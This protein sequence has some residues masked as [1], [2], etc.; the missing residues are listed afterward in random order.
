MHRRQRRNVG[1]SS[2]T[3]L[4]P[5]RDLKYQL[6]THVAPRPFIAS[7]LRHRDLNYQLLTQVAPRPFIASSLRHRDLKYQLLTQV[8]PRP[9]IASSLRH[10]DLKYHSSLPPSLL[11]ILQAHVVSFARSAS[12]R[13]RLSAVTPARPTTPSVLTARDAYVSPIEELPSHYISCHLKKLF[14]S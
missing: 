11:S 4:V 8:A 7:S 14:L 10:R 3:S 6:L 2:I 1:K 9:F 5:I 13:T 12:V